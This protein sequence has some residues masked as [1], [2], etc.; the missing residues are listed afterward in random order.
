MKDILLKDATLNDI[1]DYLKTNKFL[2][3][4]N[5]YSLEHLKQTQLNKQ[6]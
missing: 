3:V 1:F 4:G 5:I 6:Q 2:L